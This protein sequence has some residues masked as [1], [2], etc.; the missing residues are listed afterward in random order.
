MQIQNGPIIQNPEC[1]SMKIC[2]VAAHFV[3][4]ECVWIGNWHHLPGAMELHS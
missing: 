3:Y 2:T 1:L 4:V